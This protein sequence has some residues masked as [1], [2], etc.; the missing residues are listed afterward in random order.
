MP[1]CGRQARPALSAAVRRR[2]TLP[3]RDIARGASGSAAGSPG[4]GA[5]RL[6]EDL[7]AGGGAEPVDGAVA[8]A[9]GF[10]SEFAARP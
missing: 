4:S 2:D 7:G 6:W 9:T 8:T 10:T 5:P 3:A 1:I